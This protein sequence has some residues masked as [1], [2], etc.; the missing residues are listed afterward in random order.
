VVVGWKLKIGALAGTVSIAGLLCWQTGLLTA[1]VRTLRGIVAAQSSESARKKP[2]FK[3]DAAGTILNRDGFEVDL[4]GFKSSDGNSVSY[5]LSTPLGSATALDE[6]DRQLALAD[7]V[8]V[9]EPFRNA[10]GHV[11]GERAVIFFEGRRTHEEIAAIL[12]TDGRIL[13]RIESRSLYH[14]LEFE[15]QLHR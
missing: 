1:A 5:S 11:A 14:A 10:E 3:E 12:W 4:H 15:K 13:H 9:R 2:V 6:L 7:H 8:V